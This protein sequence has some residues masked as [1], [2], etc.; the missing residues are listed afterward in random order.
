METILVE[1]H[2]WLEG[3]LLS[4]KL[5]NDPEYKSAQ[6]LL[7]ARCTKIAMCAA[8]CMLAC[9]VQY[10][11]AMDGGTTFRDGRGRTQTSDEY[12]NSIRIF[13]FQ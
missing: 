5:E 11:A 1:Y 13:L 3:H 12:D 4:G 10:Y 6:R 7:A 8:G 9:V 2:T